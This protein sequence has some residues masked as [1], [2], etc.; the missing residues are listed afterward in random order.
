M[1][2]ADLGRTSSLGVAP[3]KFLAQETITDPSTLGRCVP[4]TTPPTVARVLECG[5]ERKWKG[6]GIWE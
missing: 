2:R 6:E 4:A 1:G 3:S 5:R